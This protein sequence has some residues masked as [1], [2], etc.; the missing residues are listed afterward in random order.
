ML[1]FHTN[2]LVCQDIELLVDFCS[3]KES[4]EKIISLFWILNTFRQNPC[5]LNK[6][7]YAYCRINTLY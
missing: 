7:L 3:Y 4:I 1:R 5:T 6:A 2:Y